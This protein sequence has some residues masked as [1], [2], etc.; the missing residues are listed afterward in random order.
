[1]KFTRMVCQNFTL[2]DSDFNFFSAIVL[3]LVSSIEVEEKDFWYQRCHFYLLPLLLYARGVFGAKSQNFL[4]L[5]CSAENLR[6]EDSGLFKS[7][8]EVENF[9][10]K[11]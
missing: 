6:G 9:E 8:Y 1:M 7:E 11:N 10:K 2:G 4:K 5:I 3:I